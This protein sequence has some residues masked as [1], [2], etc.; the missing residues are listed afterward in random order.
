MMFLITY[1][2]LCLPFVL[3]FGIEDLPTAFY[4]ANSVVDIVFVADI[5]MNF[6]FAYENGDTGMVTTNRK[7]IAL[8]YFRTWLIVDVVASFPF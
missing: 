8:H 3:G 6:R 1:I 4:I 5:W 7:E 2:G